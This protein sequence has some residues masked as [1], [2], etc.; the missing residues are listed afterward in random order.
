MRG[1]ERWTQRELYPIPAWVAGHLPGVL[2]HGCGWDE[3]HGAIWMLD[4]DALIQAWVQDRR[5]DNEA[6]RRVRPRPPSEL[7]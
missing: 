6:M 2:F 3:A 5:R 7:E 4:V 1:F